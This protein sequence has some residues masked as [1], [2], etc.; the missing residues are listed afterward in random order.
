[1]SEISWDGVENNSL[2]ADYD[3]YRTLRFEVGGALILPTILGEIV[4][5]VF[6][7]HLFFQNYDG[8]D[9]NFFFLRPLQNDGHSRSELA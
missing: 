3:D 8:I 1:M 5:A 2:R 9:C 7:A 4:A 6:W